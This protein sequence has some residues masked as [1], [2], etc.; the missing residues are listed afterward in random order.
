MLHDK[1]AMI[2]TGGSCDKELTERLLE[3][4]Q[5]NTIIAVDGG[6]KILD[7]LNLIPDYIVG[8]FDTIDPNI[9]KKYKELHAKQA[10]APIIEEF[11]PEKDDTDTEIAIRLCIRLQ[12]KKVI[13]LGATGTRLDHTFANIHLLKQLLDKGIEAYSYDK[14]NKI[15]LINQPKALLKK[16]CYGTYFSML[17]FTEEVKKITLTGFKYPLYEKDIEFG[18]SLCISNEVIEESARVEF[19]EGILV[20]FESMD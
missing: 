1:I 15:Y 20:I 11:C 13:L 16:D 17:P 5:V 9:I 6:L 12:C 14:N 4:Q 7:E 3:E 18:T 2:V 19:S 8:D 10:D